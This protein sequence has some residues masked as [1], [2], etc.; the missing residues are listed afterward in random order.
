MPPKA[1]ELPTTKPKPMILDIERFPEHLW[2]LS[3]KPH[4]VYVM[5]TVVEALPKANGLATFSTEEKAREFLNTIPVTNAPRAAD[6]FSPEQVT[7]EEARN[8]AKSKKGANSVLLLDD[9]SNPV[10]H[11]IR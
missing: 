11:Y 2:A 7:F 5:F 10:I 3:S 1:A 4:N 9:V 8:I 6:I